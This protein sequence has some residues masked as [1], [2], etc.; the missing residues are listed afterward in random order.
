VKVVFMGTP[1][2]A[3]P[4]LERLIA[5]GHEVG[6]VLA[7]PDKPKGRGLQL[8][9]PPVKEAAL[10]HGLA[11]FQPTTLRGG[12]VYDILQKIAPELIVVTA[13]G[14]ILPREILDLPPLGCVNMHASLLPQYRGAAPIQWAILNGETQTGITAMQMDA[15]MDTGAVLLQTT[16]A[17]PSDATAADL[18]DSLSILAA[19][20][21][22]QTIEGL[23]TRTLCAVP[24]DDARAS[25][26]PMLKKSMSPLDLSRE[27]ENLRNQVRG[28]FPWPMATIKHNGRTLRVHSCHVA[29]E[30]DD[31]QL[32]VQCGDGAYLCLDVVQPEGKRAMSGASYKRGHA[33]G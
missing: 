20:T 1:Q 30:P 22:R 26:A 5:D 3:V 14:K 13:Y 4:C 28:L 7:Q 16:C 2:F 8:A 9:A 18:H 15:G 27:A 10:A 24:Q 29:I 23:Q 31:A 17:I 32:C 25:Y 21:L 11:V 19:E 33:G 12:E 6:A